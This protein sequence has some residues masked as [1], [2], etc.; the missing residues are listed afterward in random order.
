M[1]DQK[2]YFTFYNMSQDYIRKLQVEFVDNFDGI[3]QKTSKAKKTMRALVGFLSDR[4]QI[5][6]K[7][8]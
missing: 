1:D 6:L 5:E 8:T 4:V 3:L 2:Y 7:Y